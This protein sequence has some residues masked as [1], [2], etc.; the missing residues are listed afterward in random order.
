MQTL[1]GQMIEGFYSGRGYCYVDVE[2]RRYG[3]A[4]WV[5]HLMVGGPM[6]RVRPVIAEFARTVQE[7]RQLVMVAA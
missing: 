5:S 2:G 4:D 1:D 7:S 6:D 3:Q